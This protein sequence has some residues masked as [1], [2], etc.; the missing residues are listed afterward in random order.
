MHLDRVRGAVWGRL[1]HP[2]EGKAPADL[3]SC[4]VDAAEPGD[5]PLPARGRPGGAPHRLRHRGEAFGVGLAHL[6]GA[7]VGDDIEVG[8]CHLSVAIRAL[9]QRADQDAG[10]WMPGELH[11]VVVHDLQRGPAEGVAEPDHVVGADGDALV[12]AAVPPLHGAA[13]LDRRVRVDRPRL[14]VAT[15]GGV[16]PARSLIR[17]AANVGAPRRAA[18]WGSP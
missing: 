5:V 13:P 2:L 10:R 18:H 7:D 9:R 17:H 8:A 4:V 14:E 16:T 11:D 1:H 15:E 3:R 12:D 6:A